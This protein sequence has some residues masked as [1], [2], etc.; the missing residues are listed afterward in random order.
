MSVLKHIGQFNLQKTVYD[1]RVVLSYICYKCFFEKKK[2][3]NIYIDP[4][5]ICHASARPPAF[6]STA[7]HFSFSLDGMRNRKARTGLVHRSVVIK[8]HPLNRTWPHFHAQS[9]S[10]SEAFPPLSPR[11]SNIDNERDVTLYIKASASAHSWH[12]VLGLGSE[13]LLGS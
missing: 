10:Q 6:Q 3:M 12:F 11:R 5:Y 1:L 2:T 7:P 4:V 9:L 8:L 13:H